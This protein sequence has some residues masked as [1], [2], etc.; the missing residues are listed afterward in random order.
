MGMEHCAVLPWL[1]QMDFN[2]QQFNKE[3][4]GAGHEAR[5]CR[6]IVLDLG[7]KRAIAR[8]WYICKSSAG[9][10]THYI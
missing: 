8:Q 3:G 9:F 1:G 4:Q 2:G 7:I 10:H 5:G 6:Q